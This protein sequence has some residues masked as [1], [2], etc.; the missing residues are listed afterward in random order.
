MFQDKIDGKEIC[1]ESQEAI[2]ESLID[3]S[4]LDKVPEIHRDRGATASG[5]YCNNEN[6]DMSRRSM[7]IEHGMLESWA[8]NV[9]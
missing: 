3:L 7:N 8:W 1:S 4:I 6:E 5:R 2:T 9:D